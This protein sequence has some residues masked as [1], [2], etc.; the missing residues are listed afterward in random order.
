V[1]LLVLL[2]LVLL[3]LLTAV[4]MLI[5]LLLLLLHWI[6]ASVNPGV[7]A[8]TDTLYSTCARFTNQMT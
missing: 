7:Q 2:L 1:L 4:P 3:L 8:T 6:A 5:M